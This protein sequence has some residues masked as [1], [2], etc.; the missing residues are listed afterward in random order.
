MH[1]LFSVISFQLSE[2]DYGETEN[3]V[4]PVRITRSPP[5]VVLANPV[6]FSVTPLTVEQALE[7]GVIT[8]F[9]NENLDS[10]NRASKLRRREGG[11]EG[12]RE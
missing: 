2:E 4:M 7:E 10:P 5:D 8:D 3:A 1:F 11:R 12:G 6:T 9:P